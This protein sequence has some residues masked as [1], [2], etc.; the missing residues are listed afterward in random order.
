MFEVSSFF[1]ILVCLDIL[2]SIVYLEERKRKAQHHDFVLFTA[3][4]DR[5]NKKKMETVSLLGKK[6]KVLECGIFLLT[7][8]F[9]SC[10]N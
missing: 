1:L 5:G 4:T 7:L 6:K 2:Y 10:K 3:E 8:V 9:M